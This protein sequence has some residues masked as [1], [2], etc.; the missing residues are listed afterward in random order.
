MNESKMFFFLNEGKNDLIAK[1]LQCTD[2]L[3]SEVFAR[4]RWSQKG[5]DN[6]LETGFLSIDNG[7]GNS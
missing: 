5:Q 3:F 4:G 2:Y 7:R 1:N 6:M